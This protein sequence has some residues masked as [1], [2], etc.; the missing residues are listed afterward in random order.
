MSKK[1]G[2]VHGYARGLAE[3]GLE[4]EINKSPSKKTGDLPG[5]DFGTSLPKLMAYPSSKGLT[6]DTVLMP[7][8]NRK[9]VKQIDANRLE[10]WLFVGITRATK[11]IYI[12]TTDDEN[13]LFFERFRELERQKQLIIMRNGD[14]A[15]GISD[16]ASKEESPEESSLTDLF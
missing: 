3:A 13:A 5:I 9:L 4:V 1:P 11:W 6:F 12:S 14:R 8:L 10:R 7:R 15:L 16:K 2:A